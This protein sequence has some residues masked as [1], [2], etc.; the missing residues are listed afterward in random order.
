MYVK[1]IQEQI[2]ELRGLK[3]GWL[4]GDGFAPTEAALAGISRIL[5]ADSV[6]RLYPMY[7][8]GV[9]LEYTVSGVEVTVHISPN[10]DVVHVDILTS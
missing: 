9:S 5:D 6:F 2:Q 3:D 10:G 7:N 1:S 4:H 8:G